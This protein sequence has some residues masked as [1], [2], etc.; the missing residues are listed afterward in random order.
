MS[1][2]MNVL[3]YLRFSTGVLLASIALIVLGDSAQAQET[4]PVNG[5]VDKQL[6]R[7]ALEHATV[8]VSATEI[9]EDA[10]VVIYRGRIEAVGAS[11]T[12][13][14][15]EPAVHH[16]MSGFLCHAQSPARG[17][18]PWPSRFER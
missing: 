11:T 10:T 6:V 9:I 15:T 14:P 7:T 16:D 4:F 1:E 5:T 3:N 17:M 18:E 13:V 12:T 2:S 8:H